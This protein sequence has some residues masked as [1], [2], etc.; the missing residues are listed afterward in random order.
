MVSGRI[1]TMVP[2]L[3]ATA[4]PLVAQSNDCLAKLP[5]SVFTR[6]PV[7]IDARADDSASAILPAADILTQ[8]LTERIRKSLGAETGPLPQGDSIVS[9]RQLGGSVVVTAHRD[10]TFT[11]KKDTTVTAD[12]MGTSGLDIL[13]RALAES[14]AGG[15][16]IFWP[17]GVKQDSLSYSLSFESPGVRQN[18]KL[19]PLRVR[20][21]NPVFTL[22]IPWYKAAEMSEKPHIVYPIRP[23]SGSSGGKVVVDFVV[24]S[25]GHID[26]ATVK[27]V[28]PAKMPIG[29]DAVYYRAFLTSTMRGI[30]SAKYKPATIAGCPI[31]QQVRQS[32][33]F[34]LAQ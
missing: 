26:V 23:P 19:D 11:W 18:G 13:T 6:V 15:D 16:R 34:K 22:K 3:F 31:N 2:A 1:R 28:A 14:S 27:E 29:D 4:T 32:F 9:W 25:A 10:G 20:V 8:I 5:P 7:L 12:I 33:D 30:S 24:D 21:A 17:E